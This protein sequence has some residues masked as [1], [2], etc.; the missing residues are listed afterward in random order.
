MAIVVLVRSCNTI[1]MSG[2][3]CLGMVLNHT[4]SLALTIDRVCIN[5]WDPIYWVLSSVTEIT[6]SSLPEEPRGKYTGCKFK[7]RR[8]YKSAKPYIYPGKKRMQISGSTTTVK[9]ESTGTNILL[10]GKETKE[11]A[12]MTSNQAI[13]RY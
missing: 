1:V 4:I 7:S 13:I 5:W 12:T 9:E 11:N 3:S 6:M 8:S 2:A 10:A